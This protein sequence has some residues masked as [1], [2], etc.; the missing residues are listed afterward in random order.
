MLEND[1]KLRIA[2]QVKDYIGICKILYSAKFV[3]L[4]FF[5]IENTEYNLHPKRRRY[6]FI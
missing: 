1:V 4:S 5:T 3:L 2:G 6:S